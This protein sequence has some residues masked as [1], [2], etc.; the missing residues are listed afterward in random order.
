MK[1][2]ILLLMACFCFLG[3]HAAY[4]RD[5]PMTLTQPDGTVLH[6]YA[7]GDEY[8]NYLHDE[9]GYTIMQHPQTGFYVY[10][11]KRD[12]K[13]IATE[14]VA[15]KVDPAS[16]N[17]QPYNLIS[18]EE[19]MARRKAW[20][21][22]E[23]QN[24]HR[25]D[26]PNHGTLNNIAIFIRFSDDAEFTN[27]YSSIDNDMF[28]DVSEGAVSMRSYFRAA[29]YGAIEIP[30]TFYPGHN[31][32]VIISYQ[33]TYP[34]SYFQPYNSSSNP[35]GYQDD[36]RAEREFSLLERAVNYINANYPVSTS[37]NIDYDNDGL[38][39]NVCFIVRGEV[40]AWNTLLWP[41]KWSLYGKDVYIN[42]KRVWTF[43]FQLADATDYFNTSTMCHEMNHSLGAPDLYHYYY[44]TSLAPVATWDLMEYNITPPQH[45]GAYMK[46]KY[47]HW[48]DEIPEITEAGTYTLNP[49]SSATPT[50]IAYKIASDDP[51]QFYV[52]E[53]RDNTSLF[54]T[55]LPGSGLLIYRIDTRF[56]G[57]VNYNPSEGVYDE[58]YIFRPGGSSSG[59]GNFYS[60]HFSADVDRT[61]FNS[62]TSAYPF[63]SDGTP[64]LNFSIFDITSAGSTIS[65]SYDPQPAIPDGL[66]L[67]DEGTENSQY[68]PSYNLYNYSLTQQ[69]YTSDELGEKGIITS[70]AF[71]NG[72]TT[73]TR[74][75]DFYMKNTT[76]STFSNATD[77]IA[78]SPTDLVF[79]GTVTMAADRWTVINFDVPFAYDGTS[80]VV[81]VADDNTGEW[82]GSPH[83]TCFVYDAPG[84]AI[85]KYSDNT[86]YVPYDPS[87][88]SGTV[89]NV[90]NQLI[91]NK[92]SP[93]M[94]VFADYYPDQME[95]LSPY[96]KVYWGNGISNVEDFERGDFSMFDWQLD[97]TYPWAITTNT[98][99]EGNYCMKSS[100]EG[101]HGSTSA[102]EIMMAIP[103]EGQ[104]SFFSKISSETNYDYGRF[105][106][107]GVEQGSYSGNGSWGERTFAIT[108][109]VH[110]FKWA[111]TKDNS[112]NRNDDCF[113]VDYIHFYSS[114]AKSGNTAY[115]VYRA[116]CDGSG[117]QKIADNVTQNYYIDT[118][119]AYLEP[120][121]YKYGIC[122]VT[123][124]SKET[125]HWTES[126]HGS[127]GH[128]PLTRE[129]A[130]AM[131]VDMDPSASFN[132]AGQN[133]M[134]NRAMWDRLGSI[135]CTSAGQQAVATDGNFI[136][137]AS[138]Q[139]S[140]S[141]GNRFYK[142]TMDGTFVEGFEISGMDAVQ[143]RDL[144]YDGQYF[145]CGA[146][147]STLYCLD[148]ANQTL[149]STISTFCSAI[150]H[151]SYDPERDG[152]WLGDWATLGLYGRTGFLVQLAPAPTSAY[153]SAYFKD[154]D[155]V[156]HLYLFTQPNS[157][158]QVYDYNITNNTISSGPVFSFTGNLPG[159]NG[160]AG[161]AFIGQYSNKLAFFGNVQQDPNLIGIFELSALPSA[162]SNCIE[163]LSGVQ[164]TINLSQGVNWVSFYVETNLDALK[165]AL[166]EALPNAANRTIKIKS[167]RNGEST[168]VDAMWVGRLSTLDMAQ[169]Y[170]ITVPAA[171]EI[172][173]QGTLVNPADHP[174]T[175]KNG[176]NWIGF[177]LGREMTVTN[178][179]AGFPVKNDIVKA[180][181]GGQAKWSGSIWTGAL[182][183]LEPGK[184]YIYNSAASGNRTFTFPT[185]K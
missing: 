86:N 90:K 116:K 115:R 132:S 175:I 96:V 179:F 125:I 21:E 120:N 128:Q 111:Y 162:W 59:N 102:M 19:W 95:P 56:D 22:K 171:C 141:G 109:G 29:S 99:Y 119:W 24:T 6:C 51:D 108:A 23:I 182:K 72:G 163:K 67:G 135:N 79:S 60:A 33:D 98:P 30:T 169:M 140:P 25:E 161:G 137:T 172:T 49:V 15:G 81:L 50:N 180:Q 3:V 127:V 92:I 121:M 181:T 123:D 138:W 174:I 101:V 156:E 66:Y 69:I 118:E 61:E 113:Y 142:Y 12:G 150:R 76:K 47:S 185:S 46:M 64:D 31:G 93:A 97:N 84:Q 173:L 131:G 144:T 36:E 77:W 184:G 9:N 88:Y 26:L 176:A 71:Y 143:I 57:N 85:R 53:Y 154:D 38:V 87:Q 183:N 78:V 136:Y 70:M 20:R 107:D 5:V 34:R 2:T 126:G 48:V 149:V 58:V 55:G 17:L 40:G 14:F 168:N 94:Q 103:N 166:H 134:G 155:G 37:L 63:Y 42:G 4:L 73:K 152:F 83:M 117:M 52:L 157:D 178:A 43:N 75:Y 41:H 114:D 11:D 160:I 8:F 112:V 139:S 1:K 153:G 18:P 148:L 54:E 62:S 13:L 45:C 32:D 158:A 68:L 130:E 7:S 147:S 165:A 10:A 100:N 28:N 170:M 91:L 129:A 122:V 105:Y 159:C 146:S 164:Q 35:N 80:N 110:T 104:I 106:I 16:K 89:M 151:C 27:T 65:F 39:D 177:P 74:S 133:P 167:L 44:G 82:T 124:E 145:Y